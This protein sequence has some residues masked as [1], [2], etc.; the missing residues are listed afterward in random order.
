MKINLLTGGEVAI[1]TEREFSIRQCRLSFSVGLN[2]SDV[3]VL[4]FCSTLEL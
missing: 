4:N 3:R 1:I 2:R